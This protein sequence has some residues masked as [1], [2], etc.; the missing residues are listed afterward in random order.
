MQTDLAGLGNFFFH[1][2]I[3]KNLYSENACFLIYFSAYD[4]NFSALG[5]NFVPFFFCSIYYF[6]VKQGKKVKT[7]GT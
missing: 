4:Q 1:E 2:S 7:L 5:L 3:V 6:T